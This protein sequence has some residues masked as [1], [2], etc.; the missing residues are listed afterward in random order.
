MEQGSAH[1]HLVTSRR[2][3]LPSRL[4]SLRQASHQRLKQVLDFFHG[5][6]DHSEF[7]Y[8]FTCRPPCD[9]MFF[10]RQCAQCAHTGCSRSLH[11]CRI[12]SADRSSTIRPL[13]DTRPGICGCALCVVL[14]QPFAC[15]RQKLQ[16]RLG[17]QLMVACRVIPRQDRVT[18]RGSRSG[19]D[20]HTYDLR[21]QT[22]A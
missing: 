1:S 17:G 16:H 15:R 6:L 20:D 8:H 22:R 3:S 21:K 18:S 4:L 11:A 13:G 12:A 10:R 5:V 9:W 2:K 14:V 19:A 7:S